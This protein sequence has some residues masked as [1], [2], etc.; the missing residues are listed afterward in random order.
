MWWCGRATARPAD[1]CQI[2][3]PGTPCV[4]AWAP[5]LVLGE[6]INWPSLPFLKHRRLSS[7][8]SSATFWK[9]RSV[10][11]R[12]VDWYR[13]WRNREQ[14]ISQ[15]IRSAMICPE[16]SLTRIRLMVLKINNFISRRETARRSVFAT[17]QQMSLKKHLKLPNDTLYRLTVIAH[18][19]CA[20]WVYQAVNKFDNNVKLFGQ[21]SSIWG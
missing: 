20:W 2:K 12:W 21:I 15:T 3:W 10:Q 8:F 1:F 14:R 13:D 11:R 6:K 17:V 7:S 5:P 18:F 9:P 4:H 19:V 16:H